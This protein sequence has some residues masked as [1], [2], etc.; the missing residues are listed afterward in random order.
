[1]IPHYHL[2]ILIVSPE[3][4]S[5]RILC[6]ET[7]NKENVLERLKQDTLQPKACR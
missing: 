2:A 4:E 7:E 6:L 5:Y 1:M 3:H